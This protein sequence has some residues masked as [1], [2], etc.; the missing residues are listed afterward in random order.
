LGEKIKELIIV[1]K[2]LR[3][4]PMIFD[5]RIST[6]EEREYIATLSMDEIHGILTIYEMRTNQDNPSKKEPNFKAG[7]KI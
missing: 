6:L 3:S 4:L 1:Q 2:T 5:P 7:K